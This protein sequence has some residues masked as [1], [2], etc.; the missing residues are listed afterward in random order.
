MTGAAR[1]CCSRTWREFGI[2][3]AGIK[4][5][6]AARRN[7]E[8]IRTE[9]K[10]PPRLEGNQRMKKVPLSEWAGALKG[11]AIFFRNGAVL[12]GAVL[13]FIGWMQAGI[14]V[15]VTFVILSAALHF[16]ARSKESSA[17]K[18]K[19]AEQKLRDDK[20]H[21]IVERVCSQRALE[22]PLL[23]Y[24]RAFAEDTRFS[25]CIGTLGNWGIGMLE[26]R[27]SYAAA[28]A[29]RDFE[30]VIAKIA[31]PLGDLVT[32]G[33]EETI[34]GGSIKSNNKDWEDIVESLCSAA[35]IIFIL[36]LRDVT[37]WS[38]KRDDGITK[39]VLLL[40]DKQYLRK[41]VFIMPP[42]IV[43]D[44]PDNFFMRIAT[45][46][47]PEEYRRTRDG[48]CHFLNLGIMDYWSAAREHFSQKQAT[49]AKALGRQ[50]PADQI[51]QDGVAGPDD[52]VLVEVSDQLGD[53]EAGRDVTA[54][55]LRGLLHERRQELRRPEP[56]AE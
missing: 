30:G 34:G 3:E 36:P 39:E 37:R 32:V 43:E 20:A 33:G 35:S 53:D 24:L 14:T 44:S 12:L 40:K 6:P 22:R 42:E 1:R 28:V 50:R 52:L 2:D 17:R 49:Q 9:Q 26:N 8:L 56:V 23:L 18:A 25:W 7:S 29:R 27:G 46:K 51:L 21:D 19:E 45:K 41:S 5:R 16:M 11:C 38:D 55:D 10:D 47:N 4:M 15:A 13:T 48:R 54:S 31:E